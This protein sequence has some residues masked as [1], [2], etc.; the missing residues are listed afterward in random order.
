M[1]SS[2]LNSNQA[3]LVIRLNNAIITSSCVF[4]DSDFET[5]ASVWQPGDNR[6][7]ITSNS[8]PYFIYIEYNNIKYEYTIANGGTSYTINLEQLVKYGGQASKILLPDNSLVYIKDYRIPGV[9]ST[10][11][12]GS[13]NVVTSGG[14]YTAIQGID[15]IEYY[16]NSEVDTII[17][18]NW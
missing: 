2:P 6:W 8:W 14:I 15:T 17:N 4:Y 12:S 10:P 1:A 5:I 13:N 11:T 18:E 3:G 16:T 9:D 7:L